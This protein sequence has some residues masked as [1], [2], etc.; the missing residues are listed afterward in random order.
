MW[1]SVSH[2]RPILAKLAVSLI[3]LLQVIFR[4]R[5]SQHI[6]HLPFLCHIQNNRENT[7]RLEKRSSAIIIRH[8]REK[9]FQS[10]GSLEYQDVLQLLAGR[11][12]KRL[13]GCACEGCRN[14]ASSYDRS[15][16]TVRVT[17]SKRILDI[18]QDY[19]VVID[20]VLIWTGQV[21]CPRS[22]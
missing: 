21:T 6:R 12:T 15:S 13:E 16:P 9:T 2:L 1:T 14:N 19:E 8:T 4:P 22:P 11:K 17:K 20:P 7:S 5:R 10:F 3:E 18:A